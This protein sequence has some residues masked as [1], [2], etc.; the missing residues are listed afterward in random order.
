MRTPL[1]NAVAGR[2][3]V[4]NLAFSDKMLLRIVSK[5]QKSNLL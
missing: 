3:K 5:P 4:L 2:S 1:A